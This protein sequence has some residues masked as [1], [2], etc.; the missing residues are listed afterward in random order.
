MR[1]SIVFFTAYINKMQ[2]DILFYSNSCGFS[3]EILHI[4]ATHHLKDRFMLVSVD[5]RNLK[6]P[7]FVDRVPLLYTH[8]KILIADENLLNYV[9][10]FVS[11]STLQPY[12]LVGANTTSYTDNFSFLQETE[13]ELGD[14]SRNFNV[15]GFEQPIYISK[16][17]ENNNNLNM[18]LEKYMADRDADLQKILGTKRAIL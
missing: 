6:L 1:F 18:S 3:K 17:D 16:D 2:K 13:T 11:A 15:L 12:A 8:S 9:K 14:S 4:I 7:P 10:S 5:N